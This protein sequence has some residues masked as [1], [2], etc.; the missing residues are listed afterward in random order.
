MVASDFDPVNGQVSHIASLD[1]QTGAGVLGAS[2]GTSIAAIAFEPGNAA[3]DLRADL[4]AAIASG[5][6]DN[7][8][9]ARALL[10]KLDA[11]TD[12]QS[13]GQCGVATRIYNAFIS[14]IKAQSGK[15]IAAATAAQLI[16]DAQ[17]SIASCS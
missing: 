9:V 11:A 17:T 13:L 3:P 6:I 1:D 5:A 12:A 16:S 14:D 7:A 15:H 8:G 2:S 4:Q 10:A